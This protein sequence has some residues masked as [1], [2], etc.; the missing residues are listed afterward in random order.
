MHKGRVAAQAAA[1]VG[2]VAFA[3]IAVGIGALSAA[4]I[5][6]TA[7]SIQPPNL[8]GAVAGSLPG[9]PSVSSAGAAR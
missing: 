5:A 9:S 7:V 2:R 6:Q 1:W 3:A 4:A 8:A